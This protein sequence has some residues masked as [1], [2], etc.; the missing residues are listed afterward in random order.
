NNYVI[1]SGNGLNV[2]IDAEAV[3]ERNYFKDSKKPIFGKVSEGG[4]AQEID[5]Y[6]EDCTRLSWVHMP[7][8]SSPDADTLNPSE[9]YNT[10]DCVIPYDYSDHVLDVSEVPDIVPMWAGVGK[11]D[12]GPNSVFDPTANHLQGIRCRPTLVTEELWIELQAKTTSE[13]LVKLIDLKGQVIQRQRQVIAPGAQVISVDMG[14]L[15][16]GLYFCQLQ[17]EQGLIVEKVYKQA[18]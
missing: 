6:F 17:T 14:H 11:I 5:N 7:S 9:E 8:A 13:V 4:T 2:R 16:P 15:H 3:A 10:N 1:N 18:E 12:V